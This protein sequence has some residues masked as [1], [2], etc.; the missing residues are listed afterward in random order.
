M[1]ALESRTTYQPVSNAIASPFRKTK[2]ATDFQERRF[3]M[4]K[5][6]I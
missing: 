5:R 3:S 2:T 4:L 1:A 6:K